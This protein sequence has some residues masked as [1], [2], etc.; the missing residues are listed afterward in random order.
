M[1]KSE[2]N[3]YNWLV[4]Q[5]YTNI[6][7]HSNST[8]DFTTDNEGYFEIKKPN[9][10]NVIAFTTDQLER[11]TKLPTCQILIFD[12]ISTIPLDIIPIKLIQDKP[13]RWGKYLITYDETLTQFIIESIEEYASKLKYHLTL[14]ES[15]LLHDLYANLFIRADKE[16]FL[17]VTSKMI[18]N[19]GESIVTNDGHVFTKNPKDAKS[20]YDKMAKRYPEL[21]KNHKYHGDYINLSEDVKE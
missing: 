6:E 5:G 9:L 4:K 20:I 12:N 13:P 1:T 8:P 19:N 15:T 3:A 16:N 10:E 14:K 21:C 7:F 18:I 11:L 2:T 17:K